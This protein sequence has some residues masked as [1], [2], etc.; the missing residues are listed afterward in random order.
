MPYYYGSN[1]NPSSHESCPQSS[2]RETNQVWWMWKVFATKARLLQHQ[3]GHHLNPALVILV[4]IASTQPIS[5]PT[6]TITRKEFTCHSLVFGCAWLVHAK[7]IQV[8]SSISIRWKSTSWYMKRLNVLSVI[9]ALGRKETWKGM[10]KM[11]TKHKMTYRGTRIAQMWTEI[12]IL[13][14]CCQQYRSTRSLGGPPGP[15]F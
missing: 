5:K 2:N 14:H 4:I 10:S 12:W 15:N 8:L 3:K 13:T 1:L 9:R 6:L 11:S 7:E